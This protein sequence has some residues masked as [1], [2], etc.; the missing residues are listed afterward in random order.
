MKRLL[1][2]LVILSVLSL[3]GCAIGAPVKAEAPTEQVAPEALPEDAG[4]A[5]YDEKLVGG[6]PIGWGIRIGGVYRNRTNADIRADLKIAPPPPP[7]PDHVLKKWL[8][9]V[10]VIA[11][12]AG[13]V[14]LL[15][16]A[17]LA[18]QGNVL[19]D[20]V[21]VA[22]VISFCG[23]VLIA[24]KYVLIMWV[25]SGIGILFLLYLLWNAYKKHRMYKKTQSLENTKHALIDS[26]DF[27]KKIDVWDDKAKVLID[28]HIQDKDIQAD[29]EG[30][31][32]VRSVERQASI[33]EALTKWQ[34]KTT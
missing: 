34:S 5:D 10:A 6:L 12:V 18:Y 28:K 16:S 29:I 27:V 2:L 21:G 32:K 30:S 1:K 17:F 7:E 22:A 23:G 25:A 31:K 26:L 3:Q 9:R 11:A 14:G 24:W 19:W 15:V 8:T 20:D 4:T 33:Q 13:F